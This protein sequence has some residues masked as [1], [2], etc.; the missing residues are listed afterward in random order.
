MNMLHIDIYAHIYITY[1]IILMYA[2]TLN[3]NNTLY[4]VTELTLFVTGLTVS[5]DLQNDSA[6]LYG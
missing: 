1:Y 3:I 5:L 6:M 2:I 4:F